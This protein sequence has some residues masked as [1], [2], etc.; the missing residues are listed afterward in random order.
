M[1]TQTL[2]G[3]VNLWNSVVRNIVYTP[4]NLHGIVSEKT[5]EN[6]LLLLVVVTYLNI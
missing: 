2:F 6:L 4:L 1:A 3:Q 5:E